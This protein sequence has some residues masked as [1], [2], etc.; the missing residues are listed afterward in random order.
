M[1]TKLLLLVISLAAP[2]FA[3]DA[4]K[5]LL[6][7]TSVSASEFKVSGGASAIV[8]D[9][10]ITADVIQFDQQKNNLRCEGATTIRTASGAITGND[11]VIELVEGEKKL[12]ML[13]SGEITVFPKPEPF[14][15]KS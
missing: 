4:S 8:G 2:L 5:I 10:N 14:P 1:K 7:G 9:L 13:S 3:V 12:F 6:R 11:C 15:T